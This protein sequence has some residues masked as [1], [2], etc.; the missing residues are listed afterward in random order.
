MAVA[1][2][3]HEMVEDA[4]NK[5]GISELEAVYGR[6]RSRKSASHRDSSTHVGND[7][8]CTYDDARRLRTWLRRWRWEDS[9]HAALEATTPIRQMDVSFDSMP[10]DRVTIRDRSANKD[11]A[12]PRAFLRH[13]DL[14]RVLSEN[15]DDIELTMK[16]RLKYDR[17]HGRLSTATDVKDPCHNFKFNLKGERTVSGLA[18]K[19]E[20][21]YTLAAMQARSVRPYTVTVRWKQRETFRLTC[22]DL[23]SRHADDGRWPAGATKQSQSPDLDEGYW[24][25]IAITT[26]KTMSSTRGLRAVRFNRNV[27]ESY[28]IEIELKIEPTANELNEDGIAQLHAAFLQCV[29]LCQRGIYFGDCRSPACC[30][31]T[32]ATVHQCH[33]ALSAYNTVHQKAFLQKKPKSTGGFTP[34]GPKVVTLTVDTLPILQ[35]HSDK[36]CAF[37]KT[38]GVRMQGVIHNNRLFLIMALARDAYTIVDMRA[39]A[40]FG[41]RSRR[42]VG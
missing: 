38:D 9:D 40:E 41:H 17:T 5:R 20:A 28:E 16:Q 13:C 23:L 31:A 34:I 12:V 18:I 36:Y 7:V 42:G 6:A 21:N 35:Q 10:F 27:R 30:T 11:A 14:D 15:P 22:Q 3:L 39:G 37:V 1:A 29:V 26:V 19:D 24:F 8:V 25:E 33:A 4:V 32:L 2:P